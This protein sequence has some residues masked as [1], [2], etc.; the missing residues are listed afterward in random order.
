M[1]ERSPSNVKFVTSAALEMVTLI[2]ILQNF[3]REKN[4]QNN[5]Q[6]MYLQIGKKY[7]KQATF[8]NPI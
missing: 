6:C 7:F 2:D 4:L 8:L 5:Q 3:M 1:K